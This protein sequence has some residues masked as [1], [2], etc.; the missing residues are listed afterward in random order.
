MVSKE[1]L[2]NS[3]L[4]SR[5]WLLKSKNSARQILG[6]HRFPKKY[7]R[8][9]SVCDATDDL[10]SQCKADLHMYQGFCFSEPGSR[11]VNFEDFYGIFCSLPCG[12]SR[13]K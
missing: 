10:F 12:T 4:F 5:C 13:N 9:I 2:K 6:F 3:F 1:F 7:C 8:A 11:K